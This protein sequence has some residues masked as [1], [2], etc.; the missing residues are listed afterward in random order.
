[1]PAARTLHHE[2]SQEAVLSKE[3]QPP[4][5]VRTHQVTQ[6]RPAAQAYARTTAWPASLAPQS[7]K[8]TV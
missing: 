3:L 6:L 4:Q 5:L 8:F 7:A 1:M 2:A